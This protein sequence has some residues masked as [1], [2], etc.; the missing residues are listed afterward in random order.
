[1][2]IRHYLRHRNITILRLQIVYDIIQ[3]FT[4]WLTIQS[5]VI[6]K[7]RYYIMQYLDILY[8]VSK[9]LKNDIVYHI[10]RAIGKNQSRT[11]YIAW[12]IRYRIQHSK[13]TYDIVFPTLSHAR[14]E[15]DRDQ[16]EWDS[17]DERDW[18]DQQSSSQP[19]M[20]MY[21]KDPLACF[22]S[23][24]PNWRNWDHATVC[25]VHQGLPMPTA[26][27]VPPGISLQE[28]TKNT[29]YYVI[30]YTRTYDIVW[31][32]AIISSVMLTYDTV[33]D[34]VCFS[35]ITCGLKMG[36]FLAAC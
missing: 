4:T 31:T 12:N 26:G 9:V 24:M 16:T 11:Y 10:I 34:M 21:A 22:L 3:K 32:Y 13:L 7:N 2:H 35:I 23:E 1:M 18:K 17:D 29:I 15:G 5:I 30:S 8:M 25:D 6:G 28:A 33:Y 19:P 14:N 27:H 20:S 36:W